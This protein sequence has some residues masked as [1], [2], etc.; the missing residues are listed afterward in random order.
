MA[1]N[2]SEWV[3]VFPED[4]DDE[5]IRYFK[6]DSGKTYYEINLRMQTTT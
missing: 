4:N 2:G 5:T 3:E 6:D 1:W